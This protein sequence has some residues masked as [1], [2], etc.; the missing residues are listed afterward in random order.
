VD[1]IELKFP[2]VYI[3]WLAKKGDNKLLLRPAATGLRRRPS[4]SELMS[5]KNF[6]LKSLRLRLTVLA[7]LALRTIATES[8]GAL[9]SVDALGKI[10]LA[11]PSEAIGG[12]SVRAVAARETGFFAAGNV[13]WLDN[14]VRFDGSFSKGPASLSGERGGSALVR[15]L[16]INGSDCFVAGDFS[17]AGSVT[18][19]GI[20]K[21]SGSAVSALAVGG[22]V[23]V[24][25]W[26]YALAV[27]GSDLWVGGAFLQ[28]GGI[29]VNLITKWTGATFVPLSMNGFV[30]ATG[31][32]AFNG[33]YCVVVNGSDTFFGGRF[34][35]AGGMTMNY[36][37]R[38]NDKVKQ[39]FPLQGP[40]GTGTTGVVRALAIAPN[41]DLFLGGEFNVAG[42][43][44]VNRLCAW[45]SALGDFTPF[46]VG[47][48]TGVS[49]SGAVYALAF[50]GSNLL[51]GGYFATAG[52]IAV[53]NLAK[54][55]G[56][57]FSGFGSGA[58]V[59][60]DA[61]V[62]KAPRVSLLLG[63]SPSLEVLT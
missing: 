52:G 29:T 51:L 61:A 21:I 22:N 43:K 54:W 5:S 23:G 47:S 59:G 50:Q 44:T 9:R 26:A 4:R 7:L 10:G 45:S 57:A 37:A 62:S 27:Q 42:G 46:Q 33:V 36:V 56:S 38:W 55:N 8:F 60:T 28:A 14:L 13:P 41:G 20:A 1:E 48:A 35:S 16:A 17:L 18:V 39:F 12:T 40:L 19:N 31:T 2:A 25:D 32:A 49:T 34:I 63:T 30:G 24:S 58:T 3:F 53:S 15:A 11:P 6:H